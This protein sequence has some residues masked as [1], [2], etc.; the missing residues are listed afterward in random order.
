MFTLQQ[1]SVKIISVILESQ[2]GALRL[3]AH[4][5]NSILESKMKKFVLWF[6]MI[7]A[8]SEVPPLKPADISG[9]PNDQDTH[10]EH[11]MNRFTGNCNIIRF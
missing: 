3:N 6:R 2:N 5:F 8:D 9:I 7:P 11:T 4:T 1:T 10:A